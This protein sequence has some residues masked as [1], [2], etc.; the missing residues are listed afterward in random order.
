[1]GRKAQK[2]VI[3]ENKIRIT[4]FILTLFAICGIVFKEGSFAAISKAGAIYLFGIYYI[5]FLIALLAFSGYMLIK[6]ELPKATIIFNKK[7]LG[8]YLIII[9][10]LSLASLNFYNKETFEVFMK[11]HLETINNSITLMFSNKVYVIKTGGII[12][13]VFSFLFGMLLSLNGAKIFCYILIFF[14]ICVITGFSILDF[15]KNN[16]NKVKESD[17]FVKKEVKEEKIVEES[18]E[19]KNVKP[20]I[21]SISNLFLKEEENIEEKKEDQYIVD[22]KELEPYK[23]KNDSKI[24]LDDLQKTMEIEQIKEEALNTSLNSTPNINKEYVLPTLDILKPIKNKL[25]D[26]NKMVQKVS[27][28]L[29]Q[30][31]SEYQVE[32]H[33][34]DAHIGPS[35]TQYELTIKTGTKLSKIL[36]LDKELSLSLGVKDVKIEAPIPGKKTVG[37]EVA[38]DE[39]DMVGLREILEREPLNKKD[40]KLL[41]ALGKNV[42][43]LAKFCEINKTPHL[44]VA[45]STGSGKSV[46]INGIIIS[47]LMRAKPDEVKL[48]LIDPK[49]VELGIYNGIPHLMRPVVTD[50]RQASVALQKLVEEMERRFSTFE[51]NKV[52]NIEGYNSLGIEKMPYIVCIIDELADLMMVASKEVQASIMRITQMA[53]AAGIH[54][55]VATQRPSTDIITGVVKSNIPSRISFAVSSGIDS[56]TILDQTGAEKLLG[57]GDMLFKPIDD[58]NP[59]RI[60]G[61][62]V[63]DEEIAAVVDYAVAQQI[64]THVDNLFMDLE[65]PDT[66]NEVKI[67][68][69]KEEDTSDDEE[70]FYNDVLDFAINA[71]KISASLIQRHFRV[72][73]N[74]AARTIDT[75]EERGVIG[76]SNGSKPRE[77]LIPK[78]EI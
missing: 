63:S 39:T 6:N 19:E 26:R 2:N 65:T 67:E 59:E 25:K 17:L 36:S 1:M 15:V 8:A 64:E 42:M 51:R 32:A 48:M 50:P 31:L 10:L 12:G 54:L 29:V 57:K 55:I 5:V 58:N 66:K 77:V 69:S 60:Q 16:Y 3:T 27:A 68:S 41:V 18:K 73:Y 62:F 76:P 40:N 22:L 46:C 44:L 21:S 72:G 53:R 47:I 49:K 71:G 43:G 33:V 34:V 11:N 37:I 52:K 30:T 4:G 23:I 70:A 74:K 9:A 61:A 24:I 7:M 13:G 75:L 20:F 56:R 28:I 14:A 78:E 35:F 38:N 45:G